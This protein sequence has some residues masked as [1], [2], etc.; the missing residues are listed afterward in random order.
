MKIIS[1][2]AFCFLSLVG[3][4]TANATELWKS[5]KPDYRY[6][7]GFAGGMGLIDTRAGLSVIGNA[8]VQILPNGF[9]PDI[10]NPVSV[11]TQFGPM[12]AGSETFWMYSTHLRWDFVM[13]SE[14]TFFAVGGLGGNFFNNRYGDRVAIHP[15]FGAG[16][17]Y[18]VGYFLIRSEISHEWILTGLT[19]PF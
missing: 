13:N 11:E 16:A 4:S 8:G 18:D 2:L 14:W 19:Y 3:F 5:H 15:R 10:V 17:F 7:F 6:T 9:I 1:V 12:L